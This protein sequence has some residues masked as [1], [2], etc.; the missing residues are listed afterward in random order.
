MTISSKRFASFLLLAL[1]TD[2]VSATNRPGSA[3]SANLISDIITAAPLQFTPEDIALCCS[4]VGDFG[5]MVRDLQIGALAEDT[6]DDGF[7]AI[8]GSE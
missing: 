5:F 7:L 6:E 1:A 3:F 4:G 8:P 2:V